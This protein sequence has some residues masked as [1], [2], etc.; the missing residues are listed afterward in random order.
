VLEGNKKAAKGSSNS[1][2]LQGFLVGQPPAT[3]QMWH[4][5]STLLYNGRMC[6]FCVAYM[7]NIQQLQIQ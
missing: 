1:I 7:H 3:E 5:P 6:A 4:P 2:N